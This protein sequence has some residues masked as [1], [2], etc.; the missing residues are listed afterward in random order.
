MSSV[1]HVLWNYH[2]S[3]SSAIYPIIL[4]LT[5]HYDTTSSTSVCVYNN[6]IIITINIIGMQEA[7]VPEMMKPRQADGVE[8]EES[9]I[10]KI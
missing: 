10:I 7:E 9:L 1:V 2:H 3:I 8:Q 5:L 6:N 4:L